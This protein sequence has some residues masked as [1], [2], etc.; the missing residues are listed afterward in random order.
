MTH[1]QTQSYVP[2]SNRDFAAL[3]LQN[4][5]YV[6]PIMHEGRAAFAIHSA[7]GTRVAVTAN[8]EVAAALIRQNNLEPVSAH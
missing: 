2:L 8:R 7:D 4:V 5:A 3:G 6:K 1:T